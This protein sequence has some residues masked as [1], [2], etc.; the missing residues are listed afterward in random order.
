MREEL[1]LKIQRLVVKLGTGVLTDERMQPDMGQFEQLTA[2]VAAQRRAGREVALV[3][4]GAVGAGMGVLG[5]T[6]RPRELDELQAC[7]AVGQSRLMAIYER[8]F[9]QHN[10]RVAQVLLTHDDLEHHDRHLNVRHALIT[11]LQRGVVPIINENDAVSVTELKFGDNDRLSALVATLLPAD[12][13]VILTTVE[14]L[15]ENFGQANAR[16]ISMVA[17]IDAGLERHARGT[18]SETAVGGMSTK[19]QA[20]KIV[21]RSGIPMVIASGRKRRVLERVLAGESEGTLFVPAAKRLQGRKRWIAFFHH[22]RGAWVVDEGAKTALRERGKSLLP[23][24]IVRAEGVF[25]A[26]D[27]VRICDEDGTEFARGITDIGAADL[28]GAR[29]SRTEVVHRDNLVIL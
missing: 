7:A 12:L 22:P 15:M 16:T 9:A 24:G 13:L 6:R 19:L 28:G 3:T 25:G 17:R 2:Q 14:G 20:A 10:L 29:G 18:A 8:L 23:P 4:S 27:V 26:G 21:M 1:R 11:L 5:F